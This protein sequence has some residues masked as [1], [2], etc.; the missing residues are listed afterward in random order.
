MR[1]SVGSGRG[2]RCNSR[3]FFSSRSRHTRFDW[4]WSSDVCSSDLREHDA[5]AIRRPRG[6]Q[7]RDELRELIATD[8][9]PFCEA[10]QKQGVAVEVLARERDDAV[11]RNADPRLEEMEGFELGT[12]LA[13]DDGARRVAHERL[14]VDV[15]VPGGGRE[16]QHAAGAVAA[17]G[18]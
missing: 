4:D 6:R 10:P 2:P 9:P 7:D 17:G 18:R 3:Y 13:F 11:A 15:R 14:R 16:I 1:Y 8:A 5:L 12:A